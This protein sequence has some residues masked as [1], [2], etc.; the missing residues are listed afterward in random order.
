MLVRAPDGQKVLI[1]LS[2]TYDS[3]LSYRQRVLGLFFRGSLRDSIGAGN[4]AD[5]PP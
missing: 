1:T 5:A 4:L 3:Y 2:G